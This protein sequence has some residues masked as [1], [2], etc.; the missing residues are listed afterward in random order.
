MARHDPTES[1]VRRAQEGDRT[2]FDELIQ[3]FR[4]G[5]EKEVRRRLSAQARAQA[6]ADDVLQETF[7]AAYEHLAKLEWRGEESFRAW[8]AA[9]AG[10][11]ISKAAKAAK[12]SARLPLQLDQD[13]RSEEATP[14]RALA[15]EERLAR[16]EDALADLSPDHRQVI[17]LARIEQLGVNA[18]AAR[19]KRSPNAVKKLLARALLELKHRFGET[20]GSL[21]LPE[22]PLEVKGAGDAG[23]TKER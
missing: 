15:R 5:I 3:R 9:I 21:S 12:G 14:S 16:L 1:L 2:A 4:P 11:V 8:L 7:L 20:T 6:D 23:A 22:R 19:M 17:V 13:L 18:I 10:H